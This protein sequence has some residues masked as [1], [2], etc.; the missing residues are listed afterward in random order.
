MI[1]GI[2]F[3]TTIAASAGSGLNFSW[4]GG[5]GILQAFNSGTDWVTSLSPFAGGEI[6]SFTQADNAKVFHF[7]MPPGV[8]ILSVQNNDTEN[9]IDVQVTVTAITQLVPSK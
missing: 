6:F 1:S 8:L 2:T 5:R 4:A 7:D 9:Q 3:Q